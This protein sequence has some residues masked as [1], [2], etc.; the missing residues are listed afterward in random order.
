M[1]PSPRNEH[2]QR[3]TSL[4]PPS[5]LAAETLAEEDVP[6]VVDGERS[7]RPAYSSHYSDPY[8]RAKPSEM[9]ESNALSPS[10]RSG[11]AS[12][13][14]FGSA[15]DLNLGRRKGSKDEVDD[16]VRGG[17]N[18][19]VKDYPHDKSDAAMD[20]AERRALVSR[21]PSDEDED[22]DGKRSLSASPEAQLRGVRR[23][24]ELPGG[25][26]NQF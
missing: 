12:L 23:L 22:E 7:N 3:S 8:T 18:R 5:A 16:R 2:S 20:R 14:S 24:P 21:E 1:R 26:G 11:L 9:T 4:L 19:G 17:G 15:P 6:A 10:T 25:Y 13:L